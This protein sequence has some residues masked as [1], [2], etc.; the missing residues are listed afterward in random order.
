MKATIT[1]IGDAEGYVDKDGE[2]QTDE[3]KVMVWGAPDK[4]SPKV[5][6]PKD[7]P[8]TLDSE[9][10]KT[11]AEKAFWK[12]IIERASVSR[13]FKVEKEEVR[14]SSLRPTADDT[15]AQ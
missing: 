3:K 8:V 12:N 5:E 15:H 1:Y 11:P 7:K 2:L 14:L 9:E 6:F 10:G 4:D 13:F